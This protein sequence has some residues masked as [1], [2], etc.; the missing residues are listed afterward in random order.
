MLNK[1]LSLAL[2]YMEWHYWRFGYV[3][4]RQ[5]LARAF[6]VTLHCVDKWVAALRAQGYLT[7]GPAL[8]PALGM[9]YPVECGRD[10]EDLKSA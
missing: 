2:K 8:R 3:P 7:R 10:D 1:R 4:D 5:H 6:G 9:F